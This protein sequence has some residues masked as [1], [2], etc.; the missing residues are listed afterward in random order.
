MSSQRGMGGGGGKYGKVK[1]DTKLSIYGI[2]HT[3]R[4]GDACYSFFCKAL[5]GG[6]ISSKNGNPKFYQKNTKYG[7]IKINARYST[8]SG[9][10]FDLYLTICKHM[11]RFDLM[12]KRKKE[13]RGSLN[14]LGGGLS[15]IYM[16]GNEKCKR[17][18]SPDF[19]S[20][21]ISISR[22]C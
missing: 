6:T 7:S 10:H 17:G 20:T 14:C 13:V 5:R 11:W 2:L 18:K 9:G 8:V 15:L 3:S 19:K 12:K 4:S 21:E 22:D 16:I 1:E